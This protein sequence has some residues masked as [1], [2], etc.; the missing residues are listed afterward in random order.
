MSVHV[1][2]SE[3]ATVALGRDLGRR[4]GAGAVV[5][6][7]G[8]LGAGKTA[9]ARG[10]AQG[11]GCDGEDVSSPTFTVVQEYRGDVRF[12]HVDLYRLTPPEVD[13]L[14]LDDL[15]EGSV[16]AVEWPDRWRDP[17]PGAVRVT[18]QPLDHD[19]RRITIQSP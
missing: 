6:L 2:D 16:M 19:R 18:L 14:A 11:L 4:L 12:E 5:L 7:E 3:G 13:E 9:F 8:P 10:L 17:P 1:T 15:L